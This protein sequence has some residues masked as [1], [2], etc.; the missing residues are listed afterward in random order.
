M[1][2]TL[3]THSTVLANFNSSPR[4]ESK[5]AGS[6]SLEVTR[7]SDV[8][9]PELTGSNFHRV[10]AK[11]KQKVEAELHGSGFPADVFGFYKRAP[12]F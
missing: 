5:K 6:D 10:I 3:P 8:S 7:A 1:T 9:S 12:S 2:L 4:G 11:I